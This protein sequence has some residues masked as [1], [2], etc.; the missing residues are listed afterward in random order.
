MTNTMT[1]EVKKPLWMARIVPGLSYAVALGLAFAG[2]ATVVA[3]L[4]LAFLTG[5]AAIIGLGLLAGALMGA[6]GAVA[7]LWCFSC[8]RRSLG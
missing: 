5:E 7:L 8:S 2:P 3:A 4:V 6:S 1:N